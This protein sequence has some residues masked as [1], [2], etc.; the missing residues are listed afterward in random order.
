M[1]FKVF[2]FLFL[3]VLTQ[4]G[5]IAYLVSLAT[6]RFI[7]KKIAHRYIRY[8]CKLISFLLIYLSATFLVVPLIA[9]PFGRVPL[10][11][12]GYNH[13]QPQH[14]LTCFLNRHYVV[15]PLKNSVFEVSAQMNKKFPGTIINYLDAGFP[16]MDGFPLF[17]HLS[18][19]NGQ[20]IDISFC[21][22]ESKTGKETNECPSF[23]GYGICE[24]PR[25]GEQNT[26][27]YCK[28]RG[29]WQYSFV[30][31][32]VPQGSK[33]HFVFDS[34]RTRFLLNLFAS[35]KG[36]DKIFI[37]PHLKNRLA[38]ALEKVRFH[39]CQA[40]RHDDHIHIQM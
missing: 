15:L 3:T 39:G 36:V 4:I 7:S 24:E 38:P 6:H 5:G 11:I 2:L 8:G 12:S 17:P 1:I 23:I 29:H 34:V 20:K 25:P 22:I 40:V 35:Q 9:K 13:L 18:H 16:F 27:D 30:K 32:L 19:N 26:A 28:S 14:I 21:Y 10:P 33:K 37:E 31:N